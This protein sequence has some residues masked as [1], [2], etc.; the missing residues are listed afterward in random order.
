MHTKGYVQSRIQQVIAKIDEQMRRQIFRQNICHLL[1]GW[2]IHQFDILFLDALP[3]IVHLCTHMFVTSIHD[4]IFGHFDA[5]L[6]V[7]VD[8]HCLLSRCNSRRTF[9]SHIISFDACIVHTYSA[10]AVDSLTPAPSLDF[11]LISA[12]P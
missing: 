5:C 1:L 11:Q 6:V 4:R 3:D 8:I 9:F 12:L 2:D 7:L 10:S